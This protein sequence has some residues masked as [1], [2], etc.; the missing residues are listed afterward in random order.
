M[1]TGRSASRA[2]A[3]HTHRRSETCHSARHQIGGK[4]EGNQSSVTGMSVRAMPSINGGSETWLS[5]TLLQPIA[6]PRPGVNRPRPPGPLA[7]PAGPRRWAAATAAA[8]RPAGAQANRYPGDIHHAAPSG[9]LPGVRAR[10]E[11]S[12]SSRLPELQCLCKT[13]HAQHVIR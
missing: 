6:L 8:G 5:T 9:P 7:Y 12:T 3:A 4:A 13:I 1:R 11:V 10:R 2:V